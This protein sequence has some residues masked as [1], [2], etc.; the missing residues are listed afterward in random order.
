[1]K[2]NYD[3]NYNVLRVA[4]KDNQPLGILNRQE[5]L[6]LARDDNLD[7]VLITENATPPIARIIDYGKFKYEQSKKE[8]EQAKIKR[9]QA[10][11]K[12]FYLRPVT[13][14]NDINRIIKRSI[15]FI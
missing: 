11:I 14:Q 10:D 1:M 6:K 5:A 2:I 3:I 9:Q 8:K 4:D 7:L 15:E 13:D 12:E